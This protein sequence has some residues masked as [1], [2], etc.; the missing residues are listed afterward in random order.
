MS[1]SFLFLFLAVA[2]LAAAWA[3]HANLSRHAV[4]LARQHLHNQDLQFLD[5]SAVLCRLRPVR[6]RR[7]G[8][9]WQRRY[10]F[11]FS[12]QGDRRYQGWITLNGRW[13]AGIELQ[14]F[15]ETPSAEPLPRDPTIH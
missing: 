14:P 10:Q 4:A 1:I 7:H 6:D 9:C 8:L 5:Q 15:R 11:E 12:S 2:A 3:H 13:L